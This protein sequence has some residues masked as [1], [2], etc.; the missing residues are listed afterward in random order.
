MS[1][2]ILHESETR[3]VRQTNPESLLSNEQTM[4]F[5]IFTIISD[6]AILYNKRKASILFK[7]VNWLSKIYVFDIS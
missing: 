3:V 6:D 1:I 4:I 5:N 7:N 2:D